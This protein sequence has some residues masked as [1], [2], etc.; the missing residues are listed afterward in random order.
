[1]KV[2]IFQAFG[3]DE[4]DRLEDTINDWLATSTGVEIVRSDA[5]AAGGIGEH[6]GEEYIQT[7][8]VC[9]WYEAIE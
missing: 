6:K 9:I 7:L 1:M 2:K 8:I 3:E 4:I 5:T